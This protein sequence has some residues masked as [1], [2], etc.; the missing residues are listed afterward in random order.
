MQ[1]NFR[2]SDAYDSCTDSRKDLLKRISDAAVL[3][4]TE[5]GKLGIPGDFVSR[6]LDRIKEMVDRPC[7]DEATAVLVVNQ[8]KVAAMELAAHLANQPQARGQL[9]EILEAMSNLHLSCVDPDPALLAALEIKNLNAN[10]KKS[11][12]NFTTELE[13]QTDAFVY[14]GAYEEIYAEVVR[15]NTI[16]SDACDH[17]LKLVTLVES[18]AGHE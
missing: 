3:A 4:K 18:C 1:V 2:P 11:F 16:V 13:P 17:S 10:A 12:L 9:N 5:I 14:Q 8:C 7:E 15:V 6:T